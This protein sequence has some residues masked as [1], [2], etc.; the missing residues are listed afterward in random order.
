M[1]GIAFAGFEFVHPRPDVSFSFALFD[2]N[3]TGSFGMVAEDVQVALV[4]HAVIEKTQ[5]VTQTNYPIEGIVELACDAHRGLEGVD[6][7][8][9]AHELVTIEDGLHFVFEELM[10]VFDVFFG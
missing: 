4:G 6:V 10:A 9:A 3:E 2:G 8:S 5:G 1:E 7:F